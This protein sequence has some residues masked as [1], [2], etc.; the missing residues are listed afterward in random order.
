MAMLQVPVHPGEIL[1]YEFLEPMD[2]SAGELAKHIEVPRTR[3]E[4]LIKEQTSITVDTAAR[5]SKAFNTSMGFWLNLQTNYDIA[6]AGS[7][8]DF[9]CIKPLL[10]ATAPESESV[11]YTRTGPKKERASA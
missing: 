9:S 1:K 10:V 8:L 7:D 6:K 11:T 4:R 3:I 5:L 2:M